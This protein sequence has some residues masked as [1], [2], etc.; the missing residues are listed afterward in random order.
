MIDNILLT[1]ARIC[2]FEKLRALTNASGFFFA[3][4]E[5]LFLVTSRHVLYDAPSLHFPDCIET[6]V[7]ADPDDLAEV[8]GQVPGTTS[9]TRRIAFI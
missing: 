8:A 5:R 6:E 1:A 9:M 7:R 3:R 2:T 4:G